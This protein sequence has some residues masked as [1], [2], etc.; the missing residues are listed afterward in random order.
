MSDPVL[1]A[2]AIALLLVALAL[3]HLRWGKSE[4]GPT[5]SG[6]LAKFVL[7]ST[8]VGGLLGAPFWWFDLTPS[9]AWD[10]PPVAS[11][12]LAAAAFAFGVTGVVVLERPS[13]ARTRLYLKLIAIYLIPLALAVVAL[14]LGRLDFAAPV[15]YGFFAVVIVLSLGA[16]ALLSRSGG[17]GAAPPPSGAVRAWLLVAGIVLGL[18]GIA[19]FAVPQ[20]PDYPLVFNWAQDPLSSRLIAAMLIAIAAAFLLSRG[21]AGQA[22]LA[23]VFASVYG[24]GVVAACLVSALYAK[25]VPPLYTGAFAIVALASLALLAAG[26][27]RTAGDRR[28]AG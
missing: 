1:F 20:T 13:E 24:V 17:G 23:L 22:R 2:I 14:H 26:S 10:L 4:A 3:G 28:A 9:F 25:P 15:T 5:G 18:W 11:R 27:G 7:I 19:L 21:D 16:L 12:M 6:W 8:A